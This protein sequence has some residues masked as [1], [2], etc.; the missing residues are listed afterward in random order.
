MKTVEK[1]I[2]YALLVLIAA[3]L[4]VLA[5]NSIQANQAQQERLAQ[6]ETVQKLISD[7]ALQVDR[8]LSNY[9]DAAYSSDV[10]RIAEQQLLATETTN[11]LLAKLN[12][13]IALLAQIAQ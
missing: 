3:A 6:V 7:S 12:Q 9:E 4:C 5:I 1:I 2:F 13:Q 8:I 11:L 10:D